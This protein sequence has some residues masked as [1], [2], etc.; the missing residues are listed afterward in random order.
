MFLR[1]Q[2]RV[3]VFRTPNSPPEKQ[4][5]IIDSLWLGPHAPY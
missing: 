2:Q 3:S 5:Q 4:E 1:P